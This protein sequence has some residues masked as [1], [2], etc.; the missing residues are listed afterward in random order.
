MS[1]TTSPFQLVHCD[2]WTSPI[3]SF[4][5]YK[6]YLLVMDDFTHFSWSFPLHHKSDAAATLERFYAYV[7]TQ[8]NVFV[9]CVQCDNGGEFLNVR[10][11][12][13]LYDRGVALRLSC[14]HTSPQNG[15]A[16]RAIRST[17]DILRT[18]LLQAHMPPPFWVESL[19]TATPPAQ[20]PALTRNP[21]QHTLLY[22]LR[23]VP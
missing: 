11:R 12:T 17:N 3:A 16:E 13:F 5:G 1:F 22:A 8:F 2:L 14:P 7:L 10:L 15:K 23:R 19:H 6:Y 4:S 20:H 18:L 9:Q 21:Q